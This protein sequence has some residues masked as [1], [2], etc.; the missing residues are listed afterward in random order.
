MPT[1][2]FV[3]R[4]NPGPESPFHVRPPTRKTVRAAAAL[5]AF[6]LLLVVGLLTYAIVKQQTLMFGLAL[7]AALMA[8]PLK[9]LQL[10]AA[11]RELRRPGDRRGGVT[12]SS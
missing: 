3:P 12:Q 8:V 2:E 10:K 9:I 1:S 5:W 11:R 7:V 6:E 4:D